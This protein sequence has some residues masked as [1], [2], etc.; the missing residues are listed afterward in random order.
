MSPY[1]ASADAAPARLFENDTDVSPSETEEIPIKGNFERIGGMKTTL[2]LNVGGE[3][4]EILHIARDY[5]EAISFI[6]VR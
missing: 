1:S 6:L 4:K 2:K 5:D 3:K